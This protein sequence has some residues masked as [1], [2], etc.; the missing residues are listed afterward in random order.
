VPWEGDIAIGIS[1]IP[2]VLF[3]LTQHQKEFTIVPNYKVGVR[4]SAVG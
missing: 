4:G 1:E 3:R 2:A